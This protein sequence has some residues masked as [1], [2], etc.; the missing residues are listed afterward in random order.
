MSNIDAERV[1]CPKRRGEYLEEILDEISE[2]FRRDPDIKL[3][4]AL[5]NNG[6]FDIDLFSKIFVCLRQM[7]KK[8]VK[9]E[10]MVWDHKRDRHQLKDWDNYKSGSLPTFLRKLY[11]EIEKLR[12]PFGKF[13]KCSNCN[14]ENK[15]MKIIEETRKVM[16][17]CLDCHDEGEIPREDLARYAKTAK[18]IKDKERF[19][20][21]NGILEIL[22][23]EDAPAWI[24]L[25][26]VTDF[27]RRRNMNA[28]GRE[29]FNIESVSVKQDIDSAIDKGYYYFNSTNEKEHYS[30]DD[31]YNEK[32][33]KIAY[34][35]QKTLC[36]SR[37]K[38][39][40]YQVIR[41]AMKVAE[42]ATKIENDV[43]STV[44]Y[45]W[46]NHVICRAYACIGDDR[47][48]RMFHYN[49]EGICKI[50]ESYESGLNKYFENFHLIDGND[51]A[52]EKGEMKADI[53]NEILWNLN[54]SH[55]EMFEKKDGKHV[56]HH[57][58]EKISG[59]KSEPWLIHSQEVY[60]LILGEDD[61]NKLIKKSDQ[62]RPV[63]L[64]KTR[65]EI[66]SSDYDKSGLFKVLLDLNFNLMRST[67]E[68]LRHV[69]SM[70]RLPTKRLVIRD[71]LLMFSKQ[72]NKNT[73]DRENELIKKYLK[74]F[75]SQIEEFMD[76]G[77]FLSNHRADYVRISEGLG[78]ISSPDNASV[79]NGKW[80]A[81]QIN[82]LMAEEIMSD[83]AIKL[84]FPQGKRRLASQPGYN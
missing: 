29:L 13:N 9:E 26:V 65:R 43:R 12:N 4:N 1:Y 84:Y 6:E 38:K 22:E 18:A 41:D 33:A 8:S 44:M 11:I 19:S 76:S 3:K 21:K 73:D 74:M 28:F 82:Q 10:C 62:G 20:D 52:E 50:E 31:Y 75:E 30:E 45:A 80:V 16:D 78:K 32:I 71:C 59:V 17:I 14:E 68:H 37:W 5:N 64:F 60:K 79:F 53:Q 15:E 24:K 67:L 51:T 40:P 27:M 66:K 72:V 81:G 69:K 46:A 63:E 39:E 56:M 34:S 49:V 7:T 35:T 47:K 77:Y 23:M 42:A 2:R 48:R 58:H 36:D 57:K 25:I 61:A 70:I 54:K 83:K 55:K